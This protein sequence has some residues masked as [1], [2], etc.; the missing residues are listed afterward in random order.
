MNFQLHIG[1]KGL[2]TMAQT[3]LQYGRAPDGT[4]TVNGERIVRTE[5]Y[6]NTMYIV[7]PNQ[8]YTIPNVSWDQY[9]DMQDFE[10]E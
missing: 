7:T 8:E 3:K 10:A 2:T 9:L 4:Q 1:M 5:W 6:D